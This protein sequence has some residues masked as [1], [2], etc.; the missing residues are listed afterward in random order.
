VNQKLS[1]A[2]YSFRI[3]ADLYAF[4]QEPSL[5]GKSC[6]L[7]YS[8]TDG[9]RVENLSLLNRIYFLVTSLFGGMNVPSLNQ[10]VLKDNVAVLDENDLSYGPVRRLGR[11]LNVDEMKIPLPHPGKLLENNGILPRPDHPLPPPPAAPVTHRRRAAGRNAPRAPLKRIQEQQLPQRAAPADIKGIPNLGMTSC[12][13]NA[14]VQVLIRSPYIRAAIEEQVDIN[15]NN[16]KPD[17]RVKLCRAVKKMFDTYFDPQSK[18]AHL[19]ICAFELRD[20]LYQ[21]KEKSFVGGDRKKTEQ[22]CASTAFSLILEAATPNLDPNLASVLLIQNYDSLEAGIS[23]QLVAN[24]PELPPPV[25]AIQM[26][27]IEEIAGHYYIK[28][29]DNPKDWIPPEQ[30]DISPF[31]QFQGESANY[32]LV[33]VANHSGGSPF[34]GHWVAGVPTP[35]GNW[36]LSDDQ[37]PNQTPCLTGYNSILL[38]ELVNLNGV[39]E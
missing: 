6:R 39:Y 12:W 21:Y 5:F 37:P 35:N 29:A 34:G 27:N 7:H 31:L 15:L 20:A 10:K 8:N 22:Q 4:S 2:L 30:I 32:R 11:L 18:P 9:W 14:S 17:A 1:A 25:L 23:D 26:Q 38:Y 19:K 3:N 16:K 24:P 36:R 33:G 13:I 28:R